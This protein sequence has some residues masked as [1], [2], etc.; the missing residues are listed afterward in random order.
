MSI[1]LPLIQ[2]SKDEL[3]NSYSYH[4]MESWFRFMTL[5]VTLIDI[6]KMTL[7]LRIAVIL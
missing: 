3:W 1:Y 7:E 6:H 2:N 4:P 5:D